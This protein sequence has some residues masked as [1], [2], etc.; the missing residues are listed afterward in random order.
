LGRF[1]IV[2][3]VRWG[4]QASG[5]NA[6]VWATLGPLT[7]EVAT[8]CPVA[9]L[10]PITR[11]AVRTVTGYVT[12]DGERTC[13]R[14]TIPDGAVRVAPRGVPIMAITVAPAS[15]VTDGA[16]IDFEEAFTSPA[17]AWIGAWAETPSYARIEPAATAR[18]EKFHV[19]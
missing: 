14:A 7:V 2:R 19:A 10:L 4:H 6:T 17:D 5:L 8:I 9:P 3:S 11:S 15:A 16:G 13:V 1:H 18:F 12:E